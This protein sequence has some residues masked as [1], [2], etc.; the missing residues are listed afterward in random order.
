M[1]MGTATCAGCFRPLGDHAGGWSTA[2]AERFVPLGAKV[3]DFMQILPEAMHAESAG[4]NY[5]PAELEMGL[6]SEIH[7]LSKRAQR[8]QP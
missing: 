5:G 8:N 7:R 4:N 3:L 2:A 6:L 1:A